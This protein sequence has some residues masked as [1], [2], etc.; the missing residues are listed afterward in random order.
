MAGR[1]H[2]EALRRAER[3][4]K[5]RSGLDAVQGSFVAEDQDRLQVGVAQ[6]AA[7]QPWI[8]HG[9]CE[10]GE[11]QDPLVLAGR[12][13]RPVEREVQGEAHSGVKLYGR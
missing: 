5:L 2:L 6:Q 13:R 11:R 10:L 12:D 3:G 9:G 4:E 1:A 8:T 7:Q